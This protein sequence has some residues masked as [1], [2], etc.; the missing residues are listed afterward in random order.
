VLKAT[1]EKKKKRAKKSAESVGHASSASDVGQGGAGDKT[2]AQA[3]DQL[4]PGVRQRG[5]LSPARLIAAAAATAPI[6]SGHRMG[7]G[8]SRAPLDAKASSKP[9]VDRGS[10][11]AN[12]GLPSAVAT[13]RASGPPPDQRRERGAL[14][15][16][17]LR[18]IASS[19]DSPLGASAVQDRRGSAA[20]AAV[21]SAHAPVQAAA[22]RPGSGR[23]FVSSRATSARGSPLPGSRP[24]SG[25]SALPLSRPASGVPTR[26]MDTVEHDL[27]RAAELLMNADYV[28]IAAGA[29]FSADSGLPVYKDIANV[30]AYKRLG[31]TYADLCTPDWLQRDPDLFFGFW[32]S[33]FNDYMDT[34]PHKGYHI[35]KAWADTNF[36]AST[37]ASARQAATQERR[38]DKSAAGHISGAGHVS[39]NSLTPA[40]ER[41]AL[42][43]SHSLNKSHSLTQ[44]HAPR[45][46]LRPL[47][48]PR[49]AR[50]AGG[51][52]VAPEKESEVFVYTSNVDTAFERVGFTQ[53]AI[54]E[55]HGNVCDW[56][57][58]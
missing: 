16:V 9:P 25:S 39:A 57:V 54:L 43:Q 30:D 49:G 53:E 29:G 22:S 58:A 40:L 41:L 17:A 55:I 45:P 13:S 47:S 24:A 51:G 48:A 11:G 46:P 6:A 2:T 32:G 7:L 1:K 4:A 27:V 31:L 28:L 19:A 34:S 12:A 38:H 14:L 44:L 56:Q 18:T 23:S 37:S 20:Q 36:H 50:A 5:V 35:C 21:V 10:A 52:Y 3:N 42:T 8:P 33:C 15:P 26:G